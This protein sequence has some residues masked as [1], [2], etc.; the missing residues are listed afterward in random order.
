VELVAETTPFHRWRTW[1]EAALALAALLP[2]GLARGGR[3]R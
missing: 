1:V 3:R 2:L